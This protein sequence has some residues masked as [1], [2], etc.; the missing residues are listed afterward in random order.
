MFGEKPS[1]FN[2]I[3]LGCQPRKLVKNGCFWDQLHH[4]Q[5]MVILMT[6][7]ELVPESSIFNQVMWLIGRV[8]FV[9]VKFSY[10]ADFFEG[11]LLKQYCGAGWFFFCICSIC[12]REGHA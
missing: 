10:P 11:L 3:L 6:G 12:F 2:K 1:D 5:D 8:M 7:I 9:A 4:Y